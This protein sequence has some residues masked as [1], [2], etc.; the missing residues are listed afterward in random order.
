MREA[1][2]KALGTSGFNRT[3]L[4]CKVDREAEVEVVVVRFNRTI[5]ECK[6]IFIIYGL[7][8]FHRF[9][10]TILECK[11]S[12]WILTLALTVDLIEPYWNVKCVIL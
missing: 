3:I 8:I 1:F 2:E 6:E 11:V 4:E 9:N 12:F 10:R 5:L 7:I